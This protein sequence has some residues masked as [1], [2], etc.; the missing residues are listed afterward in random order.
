[1]KHSMRGNIRG[2]MAAGLLLAVVPFH[3]CIYNSDD[4]DEGAYYTFIGE[5][6]AS[7]LQ[8]NPHYYRNF[9]E[10]LDTTG[11]IDMLS[12]YGSYTCFAPINRA[13][14]SYY[15]DSIASDFGV[16]P[17]RL[18]SSM[19]TMKQFLEGNP[20]TSTEAFRT[21]RFR[22]LK[23]MIYY[24]I[25]ETKSYK[26]V[27]FLEGRLPEKNMMARFIKTSF[28]QLNQTGYIVVNSSAN[29]VL[30]DIEV[31][32]GVVHAIDHVLAPANTLL[33]ENIQS[34]PQFSLFSEALY[35]T[36]L[37]DSL[38]KWENPGYK[39]TKKTFGTWATGGNSYT[40]TEKM[41]GYTALVE[42]DEVYR[43]HGINTF[44]D[45]VH[46]AAQVYPDYTDPD[47]TSPD[48]S[49]NRF[50]A[51]HLFNFQVGYSEFTQYTA[52]LNQPSGT[53]EYMKVD[54]L[55]PSETP[56]YVDYLIPMAPHTLLEV[57]ENEYGGPLFN[58]RSDGTGI[59]V[60]QGADFVSNA[61]NGDYH[62][63]DDILVFDDEVQQDVFHKRIR[64]DVFSTLGEMMTNNYRYN[65][66]TTSGNS[67]W[68]PGGYFERL[69]FSSDNT[70][71]IA[72]KP[73]NGGVQYQGG[74]F[75][76][77]GIYGAD[78]WFDFTYDMPPV[79][80]GTWEVRL[81]VKKRG[82]A[83][84]QVYFGETDGS[85]MPIGIPVQ[86]GVKADDPAGIG[87]ITDENLKVEGSDGVKSYDEEAL[88]QND[89]DL[90]NRGWMKAPMAFTS[91]GGTKTAREDGTATLRMILGNY[92]FASGKDYSVRVKCVGKYGHED[93]YDPYFGLDYVEM[94]PKEL[95]E[96]EDRW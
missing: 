34:N 35:Q 53:E 22:D 95:I 6:V 91:T 82:A 96:E 64:V 30:K 11:L 56:G 29:I 14:E 77:F 16:E 36:H 15:R 92:V 79:P 23:E 31:H 32:N 41:Y 40:P 73:Q 88:I 37:S 5:T 49:L 71:P 83:M 57:R 75:Y 93:N 26:V 78:Y 13:M 59:G 4:L 39:V 8:D 72:S 80:D 1:M 63:I 43:S 24:Q 47:L 38:I 66:S 81:G 10:A 76:I 19:V 84:V 20:E 62:A 69:H 45:L 25:I 2:L 12:T 46:Y 52:S 9:C 70:T 55:K 65:C 90:R 3:S 74:M 48:N 86:L 94:I 67:Y 44:E 28:S 50:V 54:Y 87:L 21:R 68:F 61:D 58:R 42:T 17:D 85:L 60:I 27:E 51:Y 7:Y 33:P 18:D 89:K